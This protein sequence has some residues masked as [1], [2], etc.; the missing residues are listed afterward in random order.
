[1]FRTVVQ[2]LR[3]A[4]RCLLRNR[5]FTAAAVAALALGLGANTA[6]FSVVDAVLLRPLPYADSSRL[7]VIWE[8]Q[9]NLDYNQ[10]VDPNAVRAMRHWL[11]TNGDFARWSERNR[12]FDALAGWS[13]FRL[14]MSGAGEPRRM[15]AAAVTPDFFRL[16]GARTILGRGFLPQEDRPG[17]DRVI[18]LSHA[19]WQRAFASDRGVIGHMVQVDGVP[20]QIIGVVAPGFHPVL[21]GLEKNPEC[22]V[23]MSHTLQGERFKFT[24]FQSAGRLRPGITL[25]QAQAD[26]SAIAAGLEKEKPRTNK[27]KGVELTPLAEEVS[28]D[29]R[30]AMVVLLGAVGCVLLICCANVAN[31]LLAR[32]TARQ[33]EL[34][35]RAMLGA[36]RVRLVRQLLTESVLLAFIGGIAGVLFA[37]WCL[38]LLVAA[39][40]AGMLPR[41]AEM[42]VDLRAFGFAFALALL[43]GLLFGILPALNATRVRSMK[44]GR[45]LRGALVVIEVALTLVLLTGSGL[46]IRTFLS[47]R[48]VDL[49]FHPDRVVTAGLT[50]PKAKYPAMPHRA[51]FIE[52]IVSRVQ[53]IPGVEAAAVTN[54]VPVAN[55]SVVSLGGIEIEGVNPNAAAAYRTVTTDYFRIMGIPLKRGRLLTDADRGGSALIVN[56]AFV[57]RYWPHEPPNSAEPLGRRVKWDRA[58]ATIVGVVGD[59]KFEGA[60]SEASAEMFVPYTLNL[61]ENLALVLRSNAPVSRIAPALRA[62]VLSVDRDQPLERIA[63]MD[64]LL[65]EDLATPRFHMVLIGAFA[66]LALMLAGVGIYGVT[67]YSVAQRRREIGIRM[68]LGASGSNVLGSVMWPAGLQALAGVV[69]GIVGALGATRVLAGFLFGVKPVDPLTFG[70]V[71]VLLVIVSLVAAAVPARRAIQVDPMVVLRWE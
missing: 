54:S 13:P 43:T 40:P 59:I 48:S 1:M 63:T 32:A 44:E 16:F 61:F 20:H 33:K 70:L 25:A 41:T 5:G 11:A 55:G 10:F 71:S 26:M 14:N 45:R 21:P 67:A 39:M 34:S 68:A 18:V 58:P 3:F 47:L 62:A 35:M 31:L 2:D 28:H 37:R 50:L 17:D 49:G 36:S 8:T 22:Y 19:F 15:E 24:V 29:A 9:R 65:D 69:V 52:E 60:K 12:T 42:T 4:I 46:L 66:A 7:V 30:P 64:V 6:I 53:R 38:A 57:R 27:G 56:E 23:T 51:R